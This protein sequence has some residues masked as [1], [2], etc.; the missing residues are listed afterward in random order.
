MR[1]IWYHLASFARFTQNRGKPSLHLTFQAEIR[2]LNH[3]NLVLNDSK[4]S[5][6]SFK[7]QTNFTTTNAAPH[8]PDLQPRIM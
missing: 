1:H 8:P 3:S 5:S 6:L 7:A 2:R 4:D